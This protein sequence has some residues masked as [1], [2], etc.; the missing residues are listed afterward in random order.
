M[1]V[2]VACM[3]AS[4]VP[5]LRPASTAIA[6]GSAVPTVFAVVFQDANAPTRPAEFAPISSSV[7]RRCCA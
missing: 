2:N 5:S 3:R 7:R 1:S 6:S 4:Y